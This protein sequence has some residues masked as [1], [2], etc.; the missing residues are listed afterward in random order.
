[1]I[2]VLLTSCGKPE[3][4]DYGNRE[5]GD[6]AFPAALHLARE[7]KKKCGSGGTVRDGTI[8]IQGEVAQVLEGERRPGH[9]NG[10][11][12]VVSKLFHIVQPTRAYFGWKDFQQPIPDASKI[13]AGSMP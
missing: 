1:M 7:L 2:A 6:L 3:G 8:E 11:C 10:V 5:F 4:V 12:T 13:G 9:F